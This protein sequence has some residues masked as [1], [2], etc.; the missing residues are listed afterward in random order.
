[1][2]IRRR[3]SNRRCALYLRQNLDA[4]GE[5]FAA[6]RQ[7]EDC[8]KIA[9]ARGWRIVGE[10]VDNSISASDR[11]K[12]RPGY[13]AL[14]AA[15]EVGE[16]DALVC[17]DLDRLTRQPRQ[18]DDWID[19]AEGSGLVLVTA[20]S[21]ADLSRDGGQLFARIKASVALA[22]VRRKGARVALHAAR[23]VVAGT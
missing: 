6:T 10:Y 2:P 9:A 19:R 3:K 21:E 1:V 22:E 23:P 17:Y 12:D 7:R 14:V 18:L 5:Q 8:E 16:F 4:T 20:N 11:R 13:N 15:F